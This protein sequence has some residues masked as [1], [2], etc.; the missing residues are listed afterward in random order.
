MI[1]QAVDGF[2]SY[3]HN[4]KKTSYNT[5][6]SYRRDLNKMRAYMESRGIDQVEQIDNKLLCDYIN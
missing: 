6:M 4:V 2:V 3:L 5:Q 1:E